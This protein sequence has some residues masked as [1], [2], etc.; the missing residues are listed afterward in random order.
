MKKVSD[1]IYIRSIVESSDNKMGF[2]PGDATEKLSPYLEPL[3][4]KLEEM[5][6]TSDINNLQKEKRIE[7]K[8]NWLSSWFKLEC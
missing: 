4:E 6:D 1:I 7:G 5:L 8:P 2:L 3:I